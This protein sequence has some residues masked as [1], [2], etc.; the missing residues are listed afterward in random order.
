MMMAVVSDDL[1]QVDNDELTTR[2][3]KTCQVGFPI[4]YDVCPKCA[5]ST[6]IT[7]GK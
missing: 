2:I 4:E 1:S 6:L 7:F 5:L 3:C